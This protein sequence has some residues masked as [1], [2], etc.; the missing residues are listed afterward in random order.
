M[1]THDYDIA[2]QSGAAFRLD[3][4]NALKAIQTN[5]SNSSS[6][7]STEAYQWWADTSAGILKLRNSANNA[8]IDMLNLDGT[9]VF[10]LEDGSA[11]AP[12]LRFADD[13]DT[14]LFSEAN[15]E[16]NVACGGTKIVS[17]TSSGIDVNQASGAVSNFHHGGGAGGVRIAGPAASSGAALIFANNFDTSVSDEYAITLDGG[18]DG[19]A[20]KEGGASG[21][22]KFRMSS[23]GK[24]STGG[25]VTPDCAAGG[26]TLNQGDGDG[27]IFTLKSSDIAHGVT[28]VAQTDTYMTIAKASGA[29]GGVQMVG[30]TDA[31]G[32]DG[33]FQ[34]R[35]IIA[36]DS[37]H[38]YQ[39]ME[40]KAGKKSG[41]GTT[42]IAANR[43]I[44]VFKNN[45]GS[46][47]VNITG[48]GLTFGDDRETTNALDDYEE[49]T[50]DPVFT[51]DGTSGNS[52][53]SYGDRAGWYVKVG[54][55][56]NVWF[57]IGTFSFSGFNSS[58]AAFVKGLPYV[59]K[60]GT[61]RLNTG[62]VM[63]SNVNIDSGTV[64]IGILSN[65]SG[66]TNNS[67]FRFFQTIDNAVWVSIKIS[68]FTSG[69][70]E[71]MGNFSYQTV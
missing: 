5:N 16:L 7:A 32:A 54:N 9:F 39:G 55:F 28:D 13:T 22:E 20:F 34:F 45:D 52:A 14:G 6:P 30:F 18:N 44:A 70:N 62:T 10:D 11:S 42:N 31:A 50:W 66:G 25:E 36:D 49:G 17:V 35:G 8:W 29:K 47:I 24:F 40:F 15:N 57:R 37:S 48:T 58:H 38:T 63:F 65:T 19:L 27:F 4:N 60:A 23:D 61:D 59:I 43:R 41:T 64:G 51:D 67:F 33:A 71:I 53:S 3:L 69:N 68:Q 26:I 46:R 1:A 2:N 56:V 21:T 12:S